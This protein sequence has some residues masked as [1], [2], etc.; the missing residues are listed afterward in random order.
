MTTI[1]SPVT[2]PTR[3]HRV[4]TRAVELG[5]RADRVDVFV[6]GLAVGIVAFGPGIWF[7]LAFL[8]PYVLIQ[9]VLWAL[10]RTRSK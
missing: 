9:V 8:A 7:A 6:T 3:L 2:E 5:K 10:F 4:R 1:T